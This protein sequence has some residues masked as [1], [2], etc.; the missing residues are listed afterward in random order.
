M[1]AFARSSVTAVDPRKQIVHL[2]AVQI[3]QLDLG[4]NV[5]Q[6]IGRFQPVRRIGAFQVLLGRGKL[7]RRNTFLAQSLQQRQRQIDGLA[8]R[9]RAS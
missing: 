4:Q 7:L 6:L 5:Y 1:I 3:V 9:F 8:G 2:A